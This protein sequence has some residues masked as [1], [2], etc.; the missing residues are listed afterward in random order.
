MVR[1][2]KTFYYFESDTKARSKLAGSS[3]WFLWFVLIPLIKIIEVTLGDRGDICFVKTL[4]FRDLNSGPVS[5][6]IGRIGKEEGE[7][8]DKL[9]H[10]GWNFGYVRFKKK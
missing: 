6:R 1:N 3:L 7:K 10:Y 5:K 2:I 8:V 4:T 9:V